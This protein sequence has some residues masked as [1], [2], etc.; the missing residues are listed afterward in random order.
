[1]CHDAERKE[2][3]CETVKTPEDTGWA[4]VVPFNGNTESRILT[5][6]GKNWS[7]FDR[8]T[9]RVRP[10][11]SFAG[12]VEAVV[13]FKDVDYWWYQKLLLQ[14]AAPG[15]WTE[16]SIRLSTPRNIDATVLPD[17]Y[18]WQMVGH[19]KPWSRYSLRKVREFGI[20][21]CTKKPQ[22]GQVLLD[23]ITNHASAEEPGPTQMLDIEINRR[24]VP[25]YEKFEATFDLSRIYANPFDPRTI[26]AR[27]TFTAPSGKQETV[28]GFFMQDYDRT[29]VDGFQK[30][31]PRGDPYWVVRYAPSE[32]GRYTWKLSVKDAFG[33]SET[34]AMSFTSVGSKSK[35]YIHASAVDPRW[36]EYS[37]GE[38]FYPIG[39]S[40]HA[41]V[42][43]HYHRMQKLPLPAPDYRTYYYDGIFR[44]MAANSENIT[45]L[46]MAPWVFELEWTEAWGG[47]A[48]LGM[49]NMERAWEMDYMVELARRHGINL[50]IALTNHGQLSQTTDIDWVTS[51]YNKDNGGFLDSTMQF[52]SDPTAIRYHQQKLRYIVARWG[53]STNIFG[54]ELISESDL[55]GRSHDFSRTPTV[56]NW[57]KTMSEY[58]HQIDYAR[59][60]VTN[61]YF[62]DYSRGISAV[63]QLPSID[64]VACDAY[65]NGKDFI[66]LVRDTSKYDSRFGK[67]VMITEYGLDWCGG[68]D[69]LM[70]AQLHAGMWAAWM[71]QISGTPMFWWH[72]FIDDHDLYF[73]FKAFAKFIDGE[74]RRGEKMETQ[75]LSVKVTE[76]TTEAFRCL[77]RKGSD[78]A[79][80]WVYNKRSCPETSYWENI[81]YF[82]AK[83]KIVEEPWT[84]TPTKGL[85]VQLDGMDPI[86]YRVEVWDTYTGKVL[87]DRTIPA[88]PDGRLTVPLP[89][90]EKDLAVKVKP[91]QSSR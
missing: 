72:I 65:C 74:D 75:F 79:Y 52:F 53:W 56:I 90:L 14:R 58:L 13:Y 66:E 35:G 36:F 81:K 88:D 70:R 21:L 57:M 89:P 49:Y 31:T 64:Y 11:D 46:W 84:F 61:H 78:R 7:Q 28:F 26:D 47:Y 55:V 54:W 16:F 77:A 60:P 86:E 80:L 67:P 69:N 6:P 18:H 62:G 38:F 9:F 43:E 30:L 59:H 8:I 45:E 42:D 3:V 27:A 10:D 24:E 32:L 23:D 5:R 29:K 37:N 87:D 71:T 85:A 20:I 33:E 40:V 50:Q 44:K 19:S 1:M 34:A 17:K 76:P 83:E 51:P 25:R 4:L 68:G 91:I 22:K 48:G 73:N 63:F 12:P 41:T 15:K 82:Q 2:T 39:H